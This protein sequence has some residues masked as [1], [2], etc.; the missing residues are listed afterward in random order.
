M[1]FIGNSSLAFYQRSVAQMAD[2]RRGAENLQTQLATGERLAR[3]SEDPVAASRMRRLD[4]TAALAAIDEASAARANDDLSLAGSA[5]AGIID[6]VVRL[7]ELAQW[8]GSGTISPQQRASIGEE[9]S[10]I[11][12]GLLTAINGR[13]SSGN[14][15]FGGET[16]G[17]AYSIDALGNAIY[18]GTAE[19]GELALG[20]GQ[21][22]RRGVTGSELFDF[23]TGG[24]A[25]DLLAF[26]KTLADALQG[27]VA[28]PAAFSRDAVTGLDDAL[29]VLT[30][31]QTVIGARLAWVETVQGR[32]L[33]GSELRAA[34]ADRLGGVDFASNIARLQQ[35]MNVLEATQAGFTRLSQLSLF[36]RI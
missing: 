22:V 23:S 9:V 12:L 27:T 18:V 36:N 14:A 35:T 31:G 30:R 10:Q 11:R 15:L 34:E 2:A 29:E 32:Q 8:A 4:R 5:L 19:S 25:T 3:A 13:D 26:V 33:A 24:A 6:D 20:G 16:G 17:A 28:D 1:S 21:S 7:R